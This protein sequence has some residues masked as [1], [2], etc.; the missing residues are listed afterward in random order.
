M[1]K[2]DQAVVDSIVVVCVLICCAL[3]YF[4]CYLK[5]SQKNVQHSLLWELI[6]YKFEIGDNV[7]ETTKNVYC[8]KGDGVVDHSSVTI[9]FKKFRSGWKNFS[10]QANLKKVDSKAKL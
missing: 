3:L 8:L 2:A 5:V 7:M 1:T 4:M 6:S 10:D 9:W